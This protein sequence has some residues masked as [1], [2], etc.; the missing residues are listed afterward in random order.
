MLGAPVYTPLPETAEY[1]MRTYGLTAEQAG[2]GSS[3]CASS[4]C[5]HS[6]TAGR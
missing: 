6:L 1:L 5:G 3:A 4:R 2:D